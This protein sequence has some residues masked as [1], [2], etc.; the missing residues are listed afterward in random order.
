MLRDR[1]GH[2]PV[3]DGIA[4]FHFGKVRAM[5]QVPVAIWRSAA[6]SNSSIPEV[7]ILT[8]LY[9]SENYLSEFLE[10]LASFPDEVGLEFLIRANSPS[11]AESRM[12]A[13][14]VQRT[15]HRVVVERTKDREALPTSWNRLL[16][17]ARGRYITLW[18]VDDCRTP[19]GLAAQYV[20]LDGCPNSIFSYG[21]YDISGGRKGRRHS[22]HPPMPDSADLDK[23]MHLGP[24]MMFRAD[25]LPFVGKFD[26]QLTIAADFDFALRIQ[27]FGAGL[28]VNE[29]LGTFRDEGKGLSTRRSFRREIERSVVYT[30]HG[31]VESVVPGSRRLALLYRAHDLLQPS[32]W[33]SFKDVSPEAYARSLG[34]WARA[35][36]AHADPTI[37]EAVALT[38]VRGMDSLRLRAGRLL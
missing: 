14:F 26:E 7:S 8:S 27:A 18:N 24:F 19:Q 36:Q 38:M 4:G 32:G 22:I 33:R 29:H 13:E 35:S 11:N 6:T 23:G 17:G 28:R 3:D 9:R 37:V 5:D 34:R 1:S 31:M 15:S 20:G 12:L 16:S 30:R 25:S 10:T 21:P 2:F